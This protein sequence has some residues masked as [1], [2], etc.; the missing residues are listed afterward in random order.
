MLSH[1]NRFLALLCTAF[2]GQA[3]H[4]AVFEYT[5][6]LSGANEPPT[7]TAS[8]GTGF[9]D[10]FFNDVAMTLEVKVGFSG[11][12]GTTTASH[13]HAPTAAPGSGS[14]GVATT[15]PTFPNFPLGVTSGTYDQTLDLTS[16]SSYNPA[17]VTANGGTATGAEAALVNALNAGKSYLNIHT[18][19]F[20]SGEISGYLAPVPDQATTGALLGGAL[21]LMVCL[22]A[23]TGV[24]YARSRSQRLLR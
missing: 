12:V 23:R 1:R 14:A 19:L 15:T 18:T 17:F 2:L 21:C 6:G 11:L 9:A 3:A 5:A 20:P 4:G 24:T 10:V 8:P 22:R 7:P 13:I 16:L